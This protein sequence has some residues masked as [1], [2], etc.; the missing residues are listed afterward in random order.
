MT[1]ITGRYTTT[2]MNRGTEYKSEQG[3]IPGLSHDIALQCLLRLPLVPVQAHA[4]LQCVCRAWYNLFNSS[5]FYELR[6][7]AGTTELCVC[8]LQAIPR[9]SSHQHPEFGV[10]ILNEKLNSWQRLPPIPGFDHR[11]LPLFC[12]FASVGGNLVVLGGWD[13]STMDELRTVYIF[14]FSSGQWRRGA[15]M[16]STR[17]FF[18]CGV[19][20]G[21]VLVAG[22][23]DR[24]KDALCTAA[25]YNLRD[26]QWEPLPDMHT[27]RDECTSAVLDGKFYVISGYIT[28]CPGDFRRDAEVY[29]PKR[30]T[31]TQADDTWSLNSKAV[32]PSSVFATARELF[33]F[34]HSQLLC[35]STRDN[36]WQVVDTIPEGSEGISSAVSATGFGNSLIV[37]GPSNTEDGN[38]RTLVYR[39]PPSMDSRSDFRCKGRWETVPAADHFLGIVHVSCVVEV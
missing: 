35:Y 12:R 25:R 21:G 13:P 2:G 3:L 38:H 18:S 34:H 14:T 28:S 8:L 30:N 10:S 22:G 33:A 20:N 36:L 27:E 37:T 39:L 11:G 15:D 7:K 6:K 26:D 1:Q 32:S 5:E 24:N 9:K 4:Q 29:D 16:P 31:W 17:S 23:H 19:L